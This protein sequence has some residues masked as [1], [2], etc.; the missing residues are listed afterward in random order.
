MRDIIIHPQYE[1]LFRRNEKAIP[2][3]AIR[4]KPHLEALDFNHNKVATLSYPKTPP[5]TVYRPDVNLEIAECTKDSTTKEEYRSLFKESKSKYPDYKCI[6][7]DGSKKEDELL[8][9]Q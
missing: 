3:F 7:T 9:Q 1:T 6:Y 2:T 4:I 8:Q 5:W